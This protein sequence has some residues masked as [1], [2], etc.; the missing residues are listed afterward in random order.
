MRVSRKVLN[1]PHSGFQ[2]LFI[3]FSFYKADNSLQG[4]QNQMFSIFMLL[5]LFGNLA[6]Q[7]MPLF[8]TQR[9][10]YEA[11]ER[12]SKAYSWKA[13]IVAQLL[14]EMPWQTLM[15]VFTFF[16]W[17]YPIGLY[18]NAVPTDSVTERG[19]L[20]F[21]LIWMFY[22]FTSTFSHMMIAGV[23]SPEVGATYANFLFS[24]TLIFC[25]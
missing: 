5:T 3:G 25:G 11:R 9:A 17:Y 21:L 22:L 7:I 20:M 13:F 16:S 23:D 6:Q 18:R 19:G 12:P 2:S 15:A 8:V 10:L 24:L 1:E 4:L 14:V